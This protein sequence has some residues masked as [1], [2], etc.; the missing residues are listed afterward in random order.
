MSD[1]KL[2]CNP[3]AGRG[4][5]GQLL[6]EIRS[7]LKSLG[8]A[9]DAV[10]TRAPGDAIQL[11]AEAHQAGFPL[12]IA[13]G[14]DGTVNEV[15][16]GL[17]QAAQDQ[18]A[19]QLGVIPVGTGNDFFKMLRPKDNWHVACTHIAERKIQ[20]CDVGRVN[21]RYFVNNVGIGFDAQV[22]IEAQKIR[23]LRGQAVY[24]LALARNMLYSYRTPQVT[25]KLDDQT[26]KQSITLCTIGNGRCSG[27]G[28]WLTPNAE[29]DDGWLDVCFVN[30]LSKPR[31]LALVPR[32]MK[33]THIHDAE[34]RTVRAKR[35]SIA[36][37][38]PLPVH[39]DGEILYTEAHQLEI[40]ILPAKL[41]VVL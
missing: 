32:V 18:I 1:A 10:A 29:I 21:N 4:R 14:G 39:A 16:N 9:T 24:V 30:A 12:V 8:M 34:V 15:A 40:E 25:L 3:M 6:P 5:A 17:V 22:G 31:I 36:S 13:V 23:W 11:A 28:F 20:R 38:E 35:I 2:I 37:S 33:G 41:E 27:G 19:G 26:I 7:T